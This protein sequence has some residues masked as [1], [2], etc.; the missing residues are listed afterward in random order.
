MSFAAFSIYHAPC[1][2]V[3]AIRIL[4]P[5]NRLF[6]IRAGWEEVSTAA[7]LRSRCHHRSVSGQRPGTQRSVAWSR[8]F[9]EPQRGLCPR[10][11]PGCSTA[12]PTSRAS[13]EKG[14][15]G[16]DRNPPFNLLKCQPMLA[17]PLGDMG[18]HVCSPALLSLVL[19]CRC[20]WL[21][22]LCSQW[23]G[24]RVPL[25]FQGLQAEGTLGVA[26]GPLPPSTRGRSWPGCTFHSAFQLLVLFFFF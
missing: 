13:L 21:W 22:S 2:V 26:S 20:C 14:L 9:W 5:T 3:S 18:T 12:E 8:V 6:G 17:E 7:L 23:S 10:G 16:S 25:W 1:C 19:R 24:L 11:D 4:I 15:H